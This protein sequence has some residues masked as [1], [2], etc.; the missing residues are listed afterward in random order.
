MV[1][2]YFATQNA[3]FPEAPLFEPRRLP[4][5]NFRPDRDFSFLG[6]LELFYRI[7]TVLTS[8]NATLLIILLLTYVDIYKKL[9]SEFT[10]GL[11]LF[12][13]VLL[14]YA[15][16]SNPIV[17]SVFGF[18]ALGLGPFAMIPDL[19]TSIALAILL[20]LTMK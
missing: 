19:F 12:S 20:Y 11:I 6:D 3:P 13:L 4:F 10:L 16:S 17:Q 7:K 1:T 9:R 5:D 8:I 14:F 2:D 15:I 18:R